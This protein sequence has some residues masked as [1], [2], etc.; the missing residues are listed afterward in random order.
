MRLLDAWLLIYEGVAELVEFPDE[1]S[2]PPYAILSHTW[3]EEEVLFSDLPLGP[4]HEV[5]TSKESLRALRRKDG[6]HIEVTA[7]SKPHVK[8]GWNKVLNTCLQACR[9]GLEYVWI[10]TCCKNHVIL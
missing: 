3:G 4:N 6:R 1:R 8:L 2:A 7:R 9:D 10:D 5:V